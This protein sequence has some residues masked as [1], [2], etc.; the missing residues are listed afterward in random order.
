MCTRD[1]SDDIAWYRL[2]QEAI[3]IELK[4]TTHIPWAQWLTRI[5][6]RMG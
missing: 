4:Y 2:G 5:A 3:V 6:R 1:G